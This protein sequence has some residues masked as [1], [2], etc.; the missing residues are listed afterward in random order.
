[1]GID[2]G[3]TGCKASLFHEEGRLLSTAYREYAMEQSRAGAFELN[4]Q[5]VWEAVRDCLAE[6]LHDASILDREVAALCIS[7]LGEAVVPVGRNGE[8][9]ENAMLYTDERGREQAGQLEEAIG[10]E[11]VME[12]TGVPLH[13]MFSLPK[14]MWIKQNKPQLYDDVW[15]FMCFGDY[16]AFLLTGVSAMDYT[17]ASRTMAFNVTTKTWDSKLLTAS[18][19]DRDKLPELVQSGGVIG[20][21]R[22]KLARELGFVGKSPVVAAGG[23]DQAC[24]ALGAGILS[25]N[26]AVDGIGTVECITPAYSAPVVNGVMLRHHFNCAPHVVEGLYLTY[27]FNFTGGSLLRWYRDQFGS[28]AEAEARK[29]GIGV[30][31]YLNATA[32]K[33]P[34][35][36]L[37]VPHF[38]GSGTPTM[39]PDAKGVI[40]GLTFN[41]DASQLYRALLEGVTYEMR[42]NMDCL[43]DAGIAVHSLRAVGG[44][45]K[46]DL[47]LQIKADIMNQPIRKLDISEAGTIGTMLLAGKAAGIYSSYEEAVELL[48]KPVGTFE[49]N[50]VNGALYEERYEQY[51]RLSKAVEVMCTYN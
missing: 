42:Y 19:V 26:E 40:Y 9:L 41:T 48:V 29:Q 34:T 30:Y 11:R 50:P 3:T 47:W 35:D 15:K 32:A 33:A 49:P 16:M 7:S 2:I 14:M 1:M 12:I 31:E 21:V 51:K 24:A 37:V 44:G 27:A 5:T 10:G 28:M 25:G 13:A 4:P 18:G 46:S 39:N 6:T 43:K 20:S 17:L 45:A 22:D 8:A 36:L 38:A 23:H